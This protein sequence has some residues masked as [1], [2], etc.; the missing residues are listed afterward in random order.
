[1]EKLGYLGIGVILESGE[2]VEHIS[3][4]ENFAYQEVKRTLLEEWMNV[5]QQVGVQEEI[6]N[7][8][9]AYPMIYFCKYGRELSSQASGLLM[10]PTMMVLFN[11]DPNV[12]SAEEFQ[13]NLFS[14][15]ITPILE[16][17][18][19]LLE[20]PKFVKTILELEDGGR[21]SDTSG[22]DESSGSGGKKRRRRR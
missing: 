3:E 19:V 9:L 6:R 15:F 11:L 17:G 8:L 10:L 2:I 14:P 21:P 12:T 13:D 18:S 5:E 1:M 4:F 22:S 20:N 16:S 7:K